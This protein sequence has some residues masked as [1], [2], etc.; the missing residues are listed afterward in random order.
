MRNRR[1]SVC[2][3]TFNR[4]ALLRLSIESVLRQS[5]K[6]FQLIISD[7][8][9][10]DDTESVASSFGDDRLIY[11]RNASNLGIRGNW[12]RC[13]D[14]AKGEFIAILPD[15]DLMKPENLLEK[16]AVLDRDENVGL[17]HSKYDLIDGDGKVVREDTNWGHGPDRRCDATDGPDITLI[18]MYNMVNTPTVVFRRACY[19]KLGSFSGDAGFAF[20]YEYWMRIAVYSKVAFLAKPLIQ[21]RIHAGAATSVYLGKND[22]QKLRQVISAKRLLLTN[23][24]RAIPASVRKRMRKQL[25]S[26]SLSSVQQLLDQD[27]AEAEA[28]SL[29]REMQRTDAA[30]L[31][32]RAVWK[33]WLKSALTRKNID[34]VKRVS[35]F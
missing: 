33:A 17:V 8:G 27:G 28:R 15:D 5:F 29:L 19:E 22:V 1:I 26:V 9:S 13:L 10:T 35:C 7:N 2:I 18:P 4:A 12:N 11:M 25:R 20:D 16:V 30:F 24:S 34:R 23:H 6:D 21:W 14:L 32:D 3:P 31:W